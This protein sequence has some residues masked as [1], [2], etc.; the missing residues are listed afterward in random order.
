LDVLHPLEEEADLLVV[1]PRVVVQPVAQVVVE[2]QTQVVQVE[3]EILQ[4]L[5]HL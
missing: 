1:V 2:I 5:P 3:L 4:L